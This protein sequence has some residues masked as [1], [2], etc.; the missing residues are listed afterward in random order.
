MK[1]TVAALALA[2][3]AS[4]GYTAMQYADTNLPKYKAGSCLASRNSPH[5][6]MIKA[7]S[8]GHYQA[9]EIVLMFSLNVE[10]PVAQ[11]QADKSMIALN[12]DTGEPLP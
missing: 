9:V 8:N 7:V 12:C 11:L 10:V 5:A 2:L 1:K 4:L 6:Y 3:V